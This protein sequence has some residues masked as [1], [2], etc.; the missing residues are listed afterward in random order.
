MFYVCIMNVESIS[1]AARE[2]TLVRNHSKL[3]LL[4]HMS[5][6]FAKYSCIVQVVC[7]KY[8][9]IHSLHEKNMDNL[10]T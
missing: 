10:A 8:Q 5:T 3:F 1:T 4:Y 7:V 6:V 9:I 2:E